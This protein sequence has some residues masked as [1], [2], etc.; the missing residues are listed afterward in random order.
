MR[1]PSLWDVV[2]ESLVLFGCV[3]DARVVVGDIAC[4]SCSK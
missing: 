2:V 4:S 1:E 3:L